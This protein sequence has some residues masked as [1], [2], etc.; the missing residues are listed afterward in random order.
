AEQFIKNEEERLLKE[1]EEASTRQSSNIFENLL[2]FGGTGSGSSFY[3]DNSL[4]MQQGAIEF[5]RVWGIRPLEDN[6]R[7]SNK[8]FQE[9]LQAVTP[10]QEDSVTV[11]E[12]DNEPATAIVLP[13]KEALLQN[14]PRDDESKEQMHIELEEA[15]FNLGKLLYFD[16]QEPAPAIEYLERLVQNY[17]KSIRSEERRVGKECKSL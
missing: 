1:A 8:S 17:P 7:R 15:Y 14:I 3:W 16:L 5:T 10:Q 11:D 13:D 2:A 4:A 12:T 9:T 6:W